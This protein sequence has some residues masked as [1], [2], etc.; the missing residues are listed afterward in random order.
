MAT[1]ISTT[2]RDAPASDA[3]ASAAPDPATDSSVETITIGDLVA[4]RYMTL[5]AFENFPWSCDEFVELVYGEVRVSPIAAASHSRIIRT[6]FLALHAHVTGRGLGDVY[7]DGAGYVLTRLP[8]TLRGPDVSFV[9]AGRLP[10]ILPLR[11]AFR[12]TPDLAVEVLSANDTYV[13]VDERRENMFDA[14]AQCWWLI[15]PRRRRVEVHVPD[16]TRRVLR[17]GETLDGAPV[18][19]GVCDACRGRV[20]GRRS[21]GPA[22][23]RLTGGSVDFLPDF[24]GSP[25]PRPPRPAPPAQT[26]SRAPEFRA[27]PAPA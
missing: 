12:V 11:G 5:E 21:P 19:P 3:P 7:G 10:D 25:A 24:T 22:A 6:V 15:D 26:R 23:G 27:D 8:N 9:R 18:L 16:G 14:G 20:C 13:E 4:P 2:T 1:I 17:E